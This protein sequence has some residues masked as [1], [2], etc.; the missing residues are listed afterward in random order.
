MSVYRYLAYGS[1]LHPG[2]L[3]RRVASASLLGNTFLHNYDIR[4]HKR[5]F[6]DGSGKCSLVIGGPGV[7]VAIFEVANVE[8]RVLDKIEG[9]E[10]GYEHQEIHV[11]GFGCCL[12]YIAT[13]DAIDDT[14]V[15]MDWYRE[16]V[17]R[18]A[19][20]HGF[21]DD[22]IAILEDQRAKADHDQ[23]RAARE[24]QQVRALEKWMS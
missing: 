14:L 17:L 22:Y 12:T 23:Q 7:H 2:R 8:Q 13:P 4:F 15:P 19:R 6:V 10:Q 18:G 3:Q 24:W 9:L 5:S 20:H 11:D 1:N 21:P 16:Y